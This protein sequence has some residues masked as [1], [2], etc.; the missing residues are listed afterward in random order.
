G[1]ADHREREGHPI[2]SAQALGDAV[3]LFLIRSPRLNHSMIKSGLIGAA[4]GFVY[5]STLTLV[6]F[7]CTLCFTP[8]LG[9]A[10]GWLAAHFDRPQESGVSATKGF[11]AGG[12]TGAGVVIGQMMASVINA[13]L[14]TNSEQWPRLME[15]LPIIME[16]LGSAEFAMLNAEQYW[17]TTLT[18]NAVFSFVNLFIIAGLGA[19]GGIIWFQ[20]KQRSETP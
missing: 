14:I 12:I 18:L 9:L 2:L 19:I 20:R 8:L 10:V 5:V 15:E 11:M 1:H 16:Q 7:L 13:T 17:Q 6:S 3:A 4:A